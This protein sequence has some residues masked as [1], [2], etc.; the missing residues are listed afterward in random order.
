MTEEVIAAGSVMEV[1]TVLQE[2]LKTTL[3]HDGLACGI[4]EAA[5]ALDKGQTHLC[6]L[7]SNCDEPMCVKLVEALCAEHQNQPN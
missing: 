7:I 4:R 5:K 2:V 1:N 6:V 3:I